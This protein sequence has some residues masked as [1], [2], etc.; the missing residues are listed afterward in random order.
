MSRVLVLGVRS[1]E[2]PMIQGIC[3]AMAFSTRPDAS[4]VERP[5]VLGANTGSAA[6]IVTPLFGGI[7]ASRLLSG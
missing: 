4:R 1:A 6:E 7:P 3:S 5:E 2:P